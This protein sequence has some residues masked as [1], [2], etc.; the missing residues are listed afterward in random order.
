MASFEPLKNVFENWR[1]WVWKTDSGFVLTQVVR[2]P[3]PV[4]VTGIK[5]GRLF[6]PAFFSKKCFA[7][8]LRRV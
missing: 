6:E 1:H 2:S 4:S 7:N 8:P 3:A 5:K